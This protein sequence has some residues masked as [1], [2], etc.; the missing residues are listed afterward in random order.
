MS[1]IHNLPEYLN[2]LASGIM[3][4]LI[5]AKVDFNDS[6]LFAHLISLKDLE[7]YLRQAGLISSL[8]MA[9]LITETDKYY[10]LY[11]AEDTKESYER[12]LGRLVREGVYTEEQV[13]VFLSNRLKGRVQ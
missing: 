4:E 2:I 12:L 10:K 1:Q 7:S 3:A 13:R 8:D 5:K 9:G 6:E 11:A